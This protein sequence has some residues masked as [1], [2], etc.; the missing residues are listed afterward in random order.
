V[1]AVCLVSFTADTDVFLLTLAGTDRQNPLLA[2]GTAMCVAAGSA[3]ASLTMARHILL[4]V[5]FTVSCPIGFM[6]IKPLNRRVM[7]HL[8]DFQR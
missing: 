4:L 8:I 6:V 5:I 3:A 2:P 7:G 1:R